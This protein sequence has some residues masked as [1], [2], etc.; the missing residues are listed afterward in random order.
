MP[1]STPPP[2]P[3]S[4]VAAGGAVS[5]A[6]SDGDVYTWGTSYFGE[7]G[8]GTSN[9]TTRRE[10]AK[11]AGLSGVT[12]V[13]VSPLQNPNVGRHALALTG[14]GNVYAWGSNDAGE[15]GKGDEVDALK[16]VLVEF[17]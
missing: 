6:V 8:D 2:A 3:V 13:S 9:G 14:T 15:L 17:E 4:S 12:A 1:D 11:L 16:P 10:P 7:L 5:I